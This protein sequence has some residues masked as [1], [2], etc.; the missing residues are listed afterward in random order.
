MAQRTVRVTP[1]E[2]RETLNGTQIPC[3]SRRRQI[4]A[5]ADFVTLCDVAGGAFSVL[6]ARTTTGV[7]GEMWTTEL[8]MHW[9]DRGDAKEQYEESVSFE[10][11]SGVV[12]FPD[13]DPPA[14]EPDEGV[15]IEYVPLEAVDELYV[16]DDGVVRHAE[17]AAAV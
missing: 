16:G 8:L 3:V 15:E 12:L 14:P 17:D 5:V 9:R 7:E 4:E 13:S 6:P 1:D 10:P 2:V 11:S